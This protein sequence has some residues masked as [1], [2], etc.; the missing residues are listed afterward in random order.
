VLVASA[1]LAD[2]RVPT[3]TAVWVTLPR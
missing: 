3:D 1:P 2:G